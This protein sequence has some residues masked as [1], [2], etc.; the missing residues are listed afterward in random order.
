MQCVELW[1]ELSKTDDYTTA[2][3]DDECRHDG[4]VPLHCG[5]VQ[6][7]CLPKQ[8]QVTDR[9]ILD[10]ITL[11]LRTQAAQAARPRPQLR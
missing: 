3:R 7:G 1:L 9:C 11:G 6:S 8:C 2:S 4:T 10:L 5:A